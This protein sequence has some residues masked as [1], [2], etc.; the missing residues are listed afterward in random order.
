MSLVV[1]AIHARGWPVSGFMKSN[2]IET[3]RG[4]YEAF[5]R[6]DVPFILSQLAEGV[7]WDEDAPSYGIPI[8][9]PGRGHAHVMKFFG[10][11]QG[12]E[13]L[14]FDVKNLLA[15]G[16]QV[17]GVVD[18]EVRVKATGRTVRALEIHLWT[19][20]EEGRVTRFFHCLDR[21]AFVEA[22]GG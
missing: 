15:G 1:G 2:H 13:F 19:L 10:A 14:R 5:G 6:G 11:L 17:A 4:I 16:D 3:V 21:H 7:V 20:G 22:Y 18:L 12:L 8:Y 9:E